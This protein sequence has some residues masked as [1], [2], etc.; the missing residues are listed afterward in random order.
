MGAPLHTQV[1]DLVFM[2]GGFSLRNVKSMLAITKEHGS[3]YP[4]GASGEDIY[5]L[6]RTQNRPSPI[7]ASEFS[8]EYFFR[9]NPVGVHKPWMYQTVENLKMLLC[10]T[11][12]IK[13]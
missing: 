7:E 2:N 3:E 5:F 8:V 6:C 13:A 1:N 9:K 12:G 11:P 10:E 4:K